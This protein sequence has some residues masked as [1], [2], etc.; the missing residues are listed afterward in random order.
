MDWLFQYNENK[1]LLVNG[2]EYRILNTQQIN[3]RYTFLKNY[4]L[5]TNYSYWLKRNTSEFFSTSN[6]RIPAH[7]F[8]ISANAQFQNKYR[9]TLLY[10]FTYKENSANIMFKELLRSQKFGTEANL[11][12]AKKTNILGKF[13][14]IMVNYNNL[15]QSVVS[16]EMLD[17]LNKGK[18]YIW[19]FTV[20][21]YIT[22]FLQLNLNYEGRGAEHTKVIHTGNIQLRAFF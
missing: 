10:D 3:I 17:G 9:I 21:T 12:I 6:Y 11:R 5:K 1:V 2:F 13:N 20:Q 19:G 4:M 22:D 18:N 15:E 16:Y 14:F 8:G 7:I